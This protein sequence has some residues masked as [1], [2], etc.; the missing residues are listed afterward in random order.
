MLYEFELG[1]NG[2]EA[3]KNICC[4]KG[5]GAMILVQEPVDSRNFILK[6]SWQSGKVK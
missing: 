2:T 1:H 3:T 4:M 5:D 6:E